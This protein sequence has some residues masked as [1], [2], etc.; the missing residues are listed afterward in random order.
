MKPGPYMDPGDERWLPG[1]DTE[2][3][4]KGI[5]KQVE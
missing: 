1:G 2:H 3:F 5:Y 4:N